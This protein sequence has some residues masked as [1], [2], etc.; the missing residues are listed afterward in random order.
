MGTSKPHS[1]ELCVVRSFT[2]GKVC[3]K[4]AY[5]SQYLPSISEDENSQWPMKAEAR[6]TLQGSQY[7]PSMAGAGN[8]GKVERSALTN[9]DILFESMK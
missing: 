9:I 8:S 7:L 4:Q 5:F 6:G 1:Y 3:P 2:M